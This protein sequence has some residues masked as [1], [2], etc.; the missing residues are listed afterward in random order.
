MDWNV[1]LAPLTGHARQPF[2]F[3]DLPPE[4]RKLVYELWL[5]AVLHVSLGSTG[6]RLQHFVE[7]SAGLDFQ[8][9][10]FHSFFL[11]RE[12]YQE[13]RYALFA[14]S[15]WCFSSVELLS[16]VLSRLSE[17][18]KDRIRHISMRFVTQ[19]TWWKLTP[20]GSL[21]EGMAV[22]AFRLAQDR[23]RH[24]KQLQTL[25][26][27]MNLSDFRCGGESPAYAIPSRDD[28]TVH[29]L[30]AN[31]VADFTWDGLQTRVPFAESNLSIV[32]MTTL[33]HRCGEANVSL[34]RK[35]RDRYAGQLIDVVI[36][37]CTVLDL[38]NMG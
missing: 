13:V 36:S 18:A 24:M 21:T 12:I 20:G 19:G 11:N 27:H 35:H 4:I 30:A 3:L 29:R 28:G 38:P 9:I 25:V 10:S 2:R 5:P 16:E 31:C 33:V 1:R 8:A 23:L 34:V 17:S 37:Q 14:R 7:N 22:S 26:V 6:V 15:T 32:F